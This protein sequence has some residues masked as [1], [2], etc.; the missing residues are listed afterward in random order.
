LS[1]PALPA[2]SVDY[3]LI[4]V[5]ARICGIEAVVLTEDGF[6]N[7]FFDEVLTIAGRS[8]LIGSPGSKKKKSAHREH[9]ENVLSR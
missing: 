6:A 5:G 2:P 4:D 8:I 1:Q 3:W 9:N 7:T